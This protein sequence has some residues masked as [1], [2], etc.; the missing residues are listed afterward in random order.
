MAPRFGPES[1][2]F[3]LS[4]NG[5]GAGL[6][7]L[8]AGE[9]NEIWPG[10]DEPLLESPAVSVAGDRVA[11]VSRRQG[12]PRL[13]VISA[14]GTNPQPLADSIT[15]Q[16][17]PTWSP[18][19]K[20]IA[21]G[22]SDAEGAGLFKIPIDNGKPTCLVRGSAADPV[23]SSSNHVIVYVG[24][25]SGFAPL[26][27]IRDDDGSRVTFPDIQIPG[28]GRGLVRFMPDGNRLVY[29][30]RDVGGPDDFWQLDMTTNHSQR[31]TRIAGGVQA[32]T[33]GITSNGSSIVFDRPLG[34]SNI[35][36]IDLPKPASR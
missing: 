19:G 1:S 29:L 22:G 35:A 30:R 10:S 31:L 5:V 28:G 14:D 33:F 13:T 17:A 34:R 15:I 9:P 8:L 20:F 21:A 24:P 25:Q 3:Y 36:L 26:V 7:R 12:R 16:G 4:S 32:N 18:D 23:W 27:A 11:V 2:L 6:W